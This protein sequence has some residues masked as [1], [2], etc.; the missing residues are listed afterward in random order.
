MEKYCPNCGNVYN[1][2]KAK[3]CTNC[4]TKLEIRYGRQPIPRKLR[5]EVFKRDGFCCREC[6][7]SKDETS[8]EI[9][10][11]LPVAKGGTNDIDN[12]QTLC[13]ECNRMKHTDEWVG[14]KTD[15][16]VAENE[17]K[18]LEKQLSSF[19]SELSNCSEENKILDYKFKIKKLETE[20]IPNVKNKINR[21]IHENK[22]AELNNQK[23]QE[24]EILFKKLYVSLSQEI[25]LG[26]SNWAFCEFSF[27]QPS[28]DQSLK[29]LTDNYSEK[30]IY[31]LINNYE[32]EK[33]NTTTESIYEL[34]GLD[35]LIILKDG[36]NLTSWNDVTWQYDDKGKFNNDII[37]ISEDLSYEED[38]TEKY[39]GLIQLK[40]IQLFGISNKVKSM[41][42]MFDDCFSLVDIYSLN[43]LD[44]S[45]IGDMEGLFKN[46]YSL[47]NI[48]ALLNWNTCNV[49][50]MNGMFNNCNSLVTV[51]ALKKWDTSKVESMCDMF[52][53]CKSLSDI[54][55]LGQWN[56]S[57]VKDMGYMFDNCKSITNVSSLKNWDTSKVES[58]EL[59]FGGVSDLKN[60]SA[61]KT[62]DLSS[63]VY[64]AG[65][66]MGNKF[67][68]DRKAEWDDGSNVLF[69]NTK[70][71]FIKNKEIK[72][73]VE[74]HRNKQKLEKQRYK[75]QKELNNQKVDK[76]KIIKLLSERL[77]LREC[78]SKIF[79]I[80]SSQRDIVLILTIIN[81]N[82]ID[83]EN[84]II[85]CSDGTGTIN[86]L[87]SETYGV[88][89]YDYETIVKGDIVI[90]E[91][92]IVENEFDTEGV[93][94]NIV[95]APS[96]RYWN[97]NIKLRDFYNGTYW[98]SW[99]SILEPKVFK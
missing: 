61:L 8:L 48:Q 87:I 3:F 78:P 29:Y 56:V 7:A 22:L 19:K 95:C 15:L 66:F 71:E 62:W 53:N 94:K 25:L 23:Q 33:L 31:S 11:I 63:I 72:K 16:E 42:N 99:N 77:D 26:L 21:L 70:W 18:V 40:A 86:L 59:M 80:G 12:L 4:A 73:I 34:N 9:D 46:C 76:I 83:D 35:V 1:D 74:E 50:N 51:S 68:I 43:N 67:H 64:H 91:V 96:R 2:L 85:E 49:K 55:S 6:G 14:G 20:D 30:E 75:Q 38:L 90:V 27:K 88:Y 5:H 10:H 54:S 84:T 24:K 98:L 47:K 52:K 45:N 82:E 81:I 92:D 93:V 17:L 89:S 97:D 36:T 13:R 79:E 58:M 32:F 65:M 57:N 28:I 44:V 41:K 39:A 60:I 37:F 69:K